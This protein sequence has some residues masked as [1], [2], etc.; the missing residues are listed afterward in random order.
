MT[1]DKQSTPG[2]DSPGT[3]AEATT[4][5]DEAVEQAR[6]QEELIAHTVVEESDLP[7]SIRQITVEVPREA[8]DARLEKLF[9]EWRRE[10]AVEGFRPGKVPMK[11]LQR[12]FQKEA[13]DD[14]VSKI[15]P[16]IIA[17]YEKARNLTVYGAPAVDPVTVEPDKPVR[18]VIRLEIKPVVE[19]KDYTGLTVEVPSYT[20][21]PAMIESRL[22]GLL[23]DNATYAEA[24]KAW[25]PGLALAVDM[26]IVDAKGRT[27][28]QVSDRFIQHPEHSLPDKLVDALKGKKAGD[29]VEVRTTLQPDQK[30]V[31]A[32]TVTIRSVKELRVPDLNDEFAKD[33]GYENLAA[34]RASVEAE[35]KKRADALSSEEAFDVLMTK[36]A[37]THDFP[38]PPTL[39][40]HVA[41]DIARSDYRFMYYT[42]QRPRRAEGKSRQEY[43]EQ[44]QTDARTRVKGFL[45]AEA[46]ARKENIEATEADIAA[47]LEQRAAEEGRKPLAIR[48]ALE[49]ERKFD[50]FVEQVRFDKLRAF[51]LS[52]NTIKYVASAASEGTDEKG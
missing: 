52:H 26:K 36:L 45:L 49:K 10:A 21:T 38:V 13:A 32:F 50:Q 8:W 15:A 5:L 40:A 25:E 48:A 14:L 9:K 20:I 7:D 30:D 12:R 24:D 18:L 46:I 23:H 41:E 1:D 34:L 22:L 11:L 2:A 51:L 35:E 47:A 31:K 39:L 4:V 27:E 6:Q 16:P 33:L 19:P 43:R 28:Q 17:E 44:L 37:E 42:G 29:T 3:S